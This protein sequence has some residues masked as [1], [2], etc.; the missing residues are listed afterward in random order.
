MVYSLRAT[1]SLATLI[2]NLLLTQSLYGVCVGYSVASAYLLVISIGI[3]MRNILA[4]ALTL[5]SLPV[6]HCLLVH[7]LLVT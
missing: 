5:L 3:T 2:A 6:R 4:R 1:S 7:V